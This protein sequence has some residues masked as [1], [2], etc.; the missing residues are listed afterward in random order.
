M[1]H[2]QRPHENLNAGHDPAGRHATKQ[3]PSTPTAGK[4]A[5]EPGRS[6]PPGR[7]DFVTGRPHRVGDLLRFGEDHN[8]DA[9]IAVDLQPPLTVRVSMLFSA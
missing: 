9:L 8:V 3:P 4:T 1:A 6:V 5:G 2:S 7:A